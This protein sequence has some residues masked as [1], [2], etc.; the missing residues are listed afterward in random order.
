MQF[1]IEKFSSNSNARAGILTLPHGKVKT[2]QFMPVGTRGSVKALSS[3]DLESAG[4]EIILGN[5]YHLMLRP[6]MQVLKKVG[7][8]N[9]F[10]N[11]EKPILTDSGGFQVFSLKNLRKLTDKGV[12]FSSHIDGSKCFLG[13]VECMNIQAAI[14]S[15]IRMVLDECPPWPCSERQMKEAM[16]RSTLW[17]V[18]CKKHQPDDGSALFAIVQGGVYKDLR[19]EHFE[20][21]NSYDFDAYAIG[22]VSVGEPNEEM[23]EI[24]K[25]MGEIL[26]LNKPRY[27]M[28]IGTPHDL[29]NQIS[30]GIDMFDCVMPTRNGRN[31]TAFTSQGR[32]NMRNIQYETDMSP[33]D[34]ECKCYVCKNYTKA[35]IRHLLKVKEILG[36]HLMSYHNTFFYLNLMRLARNAILNDRFEI[37]KDIQFNNWKRN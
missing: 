28:G 4:A 22:G 26:P 37:F 36:L 2:P 29:L 13:P 19:I 30:H 24:G 7:G 33:I 8:L 21:L 35:Y 34:K 17:A 3:E 16:R 27:M 14:G 15:D 12:F 25:Y 5:T 32:V 18:E 10:M 6:G 11:W 20:Q 31:G 23:L 9:K 1:K